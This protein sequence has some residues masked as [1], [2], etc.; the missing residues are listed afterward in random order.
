[1]D[2]IKEVKK[3]IIQNIQNMHTADQ[4][5]RI[6]V[7]KMAKEICQLF[8]PKPDPNCPKCKGKGQYYFCLPDDVGSPNLIKCDYMKPKP[9]ESRL[10][11]MRK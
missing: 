3:I 4:I 10:L 5:I 9:D 8:E 6:G 11:K 2:K 1:M 7:P